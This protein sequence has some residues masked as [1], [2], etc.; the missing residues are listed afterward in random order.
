MRR[1]APPPLS[2]A[3]RAPPSWP[4]AALL[5]GLLSANAA[6]WAWAGVSF[7]GSPL[8]L[9][10]ALLAYVLGL[11]H[12]VD[13]DHIAAIDNVVRKLMHLRGR[14]PY[15]V[16][17]FFSAGHSTLI[18]G[19]VL[20]ATLSGALGPHFASLRRVGGLVAITVSA[21]F[22]MLIALANVA[23]LRES[24][25]DYRRLRATPLLQ[26]GGGALRP[27]KGPVARLL[28]PLLNSISASW[29]MFLIGLLFALGFDTASEVG[30]FAVTAQ[31]AEGLSVRAAMIFPL[32]FAAGMMLVDTADSILMVGAYGWALRDPLRKLRYNLTITVLS[33]AVA[34]VIGAVEIAGLLAGQLEL[35][36]M[37]RNGL[38]WLNQ[39]LSGFGWI[40]VALFAV[41][42]IVSVLRFRRQPPA[43]VAAPLHGGKSCE[44]V[45]R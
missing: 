6:L 30:L 7:A 15:A 1:P 13:V 14:R 17:L 32:L 42:W 33:V 41:L 21:A 43:V 22:L 9:N 23:V 36:G 26:A 3:R 38:E 27:G 4:A 12:A 16:G 24:W 40:I 8:L 31:Q 2:P 37:L 29:Q 35:Q 10:A 20:A 18:V 5:A 28:G 39:A 25:A 11:R 44:D 19:A 34:F 45:P